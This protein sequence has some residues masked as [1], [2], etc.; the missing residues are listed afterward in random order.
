MSQGIELG[1]P[2]P[3]ILHR[4]E[5]WWVV[6]K[7]CGWHTVQNRQ[8]DGALVLQDWLG[9]EHPLSLGEGQGLLEEGIVQRLD[10]STSGCVL[11]ARTASQYE[12][13]RKQVSL[14]SG[15]VAKRYLALVVPGLARY[16]DFELLFFSRYKGSQK[17]TVKE[18]G[19]KGALG[20]CRWKVLERAT[21]DWNAEKVE[22]WLEGPGQRHQIRA[23][24][25][26]LGHPLVGDT[27][28]GGPADPRLPLGAALHASSVRVGDV[29]VTAP[30]PV[31][32]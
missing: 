27:L 1:G 3:E 24:L 23:G 13:L 28:Y 9:R 4:G 17:V 26:F 15:G 19:I 32:G 30:L 12:W 16:G 7:P 25:A 18:R 6:N 31:W 5:G 22:I 2:Q 11:V 10:V 14:D 21:A 20:R 8:T 29:E